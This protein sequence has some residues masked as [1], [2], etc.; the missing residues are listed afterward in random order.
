[1]LCYEL[2]PTLSFWSLVGFYRDLI[3]RLLVSCGP[4][5]CP[6]KFHDGIAREPHIAT[7]G[8][9]DW[10]LSRAY[11]VWGVGLSV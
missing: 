1:M 2:A 7:P 9:R 5:P 10:K 4:P 6:S 8:T 3:D 11:T